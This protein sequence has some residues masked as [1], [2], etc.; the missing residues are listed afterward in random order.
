MERIIT[1]QTAAEA[2]YPGMTFDYSL[3]QPLVDQVSKD[4]DGFYL[5]SHFVFG[6]PEG[7]TWGILAP[8]SAE[9]L[10]F[11]ERAGFAHLKPETVLL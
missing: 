8:I 5:P 2:S 3:P 6:Y 7:T 10:R 4:Y 9:G 11:A 1:K